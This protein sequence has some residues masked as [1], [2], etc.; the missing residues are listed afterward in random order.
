MSDFEKKYYEADSL[1][2]GEMLHDVANQTRIAETGKMIPAKVSSLADIGC[3]NGIFENYLLETRPGLR[4]MGVDRSEAAL[5]YVVTEKKVGDILDIPLPDRSFDCVTCLEVLEHIPVNTYAKALAELSRVSGEYILISVPYNEDLMANSTTCPGCRATFNY[6]LHFRSYSDEAI[7]GLFQ[8]YG[9]ELVGKKTLIQSKML[10]GVDTIK[11]M[12][13]IK[14]IHKTV[15]YSPI[16]PICG[17]ENESFMPSQHSEN[18]QQS[19][20]AKAPG[21]KKILT[22]GIR[23]FWP[24]KNFPGYWV[25]A[26][27]KRKSI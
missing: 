11:S 6:D 17:L 20:G 14:P 24:K 2:S 21:L 26:L 19:G 22:N 25:V 5:K 13:G 27:Y 3:G 12:L 16:C 8:P 4:I 10:M 9:F 1:W 15:F 7:E 18:K 23:M